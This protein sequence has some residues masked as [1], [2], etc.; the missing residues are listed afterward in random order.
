MR[1][2][3]LERI[4]KGFMKN[5]RLVATVII[6]ICAIVYLGDFVINRDHPYAELGAGV[7]SLLLSIVLIVVSVKERK[8]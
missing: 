5:I 4:T 3:T 8:K 1:H 6:L 2:S 7:S